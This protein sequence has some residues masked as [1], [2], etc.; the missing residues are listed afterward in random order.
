VLALALTLL[1]LAPPGESPHHLLLELAGGTPADRLGAAVAAAGDLDGDGRPDLIVGAPRAGVPP[2]DAPVPGEARV[3]SGAD[4]RLLR[5]LAP[6]PGAAWAGT[7]VAGAGDVD[8]DG[9]P[10]VLVGAPLGSGPGGPAPGGAAGIALLHSGSDGSVLRV[11]EGDAA[12]DRL[13]EA[14]CGPG[15]LNGDGVPDLVV[16]AP[17]ASTGGTRAGFVRA[18]SGADGTT[19][20][21]LYGDPWD[22]LGS[23]VAACGDV[24]GDGTPDLVVGAPLSDDGAF[25]GGSAYLVS[26][27]TG[28]VLRA[29]HG[30]GVGD[31]LGERVAGAGDVDADGVP[32]LVLVAP[33]ADADGIDTGAAEVRSG[34]DGALLLRIAGGAP[35]TFLSAACGAGDVDGDGHADVAVGEPSL[36]TAGGGSEA[37]RVR[38]VSGRTG[39]V[40]RTHEGEAPMAWL[41]AALAAPGDTSGD[42]VPDLAAGAPGHDD[43]ADAH[44]AVH[45]F[46]GAPLSLW[47]DAHALSLDAGGARELRLAAPISLAGEVY[48]VLG[49]AAGTA[50]PLVLDGHA[51]PLAFEPVYMLH[52]LLH[53]G[54]APLT[55][56][57]GLLDPEGGAAARFELPPSAP[58]VP[59][60]L[61]LHH[62]A[63]V[64]GT[65]GAALF[66]SNAVPLRLED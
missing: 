28:A 17:H 52:T 41:G 65:D 46:S 27:A 58:G 22:F 10:D 42:G 35:G 59:A 49:S 25:N 12:G 44:G 47:S 13:G 48:L 29:F 51:L 16:G 39:A 2:V 9:T 30:T 5:V 38:V 31:R 55:G 40:L 45:L 20:F 26:G 19:L 56:A 64:L 61:V 53:P 34:A 24:D 60:G 43:D 33:G 37:G 3:Y 23:A 57:A 36:D 11:L 6:P 66:A 62:A 4:G 15:D 8:G 1:A 14:V 50:P 32:D 63:L 21:E 54:A 18:H 7:S